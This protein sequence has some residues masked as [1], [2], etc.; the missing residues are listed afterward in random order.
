MVTWSLSKQE[1][2]RII[3]TNVLPTEVDCLIEFCPGVGYDMSLSRSMYIV[4]KEHPR[5]S[6]YVP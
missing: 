6:F 4:K 2:I 3:H 1:L 5:S